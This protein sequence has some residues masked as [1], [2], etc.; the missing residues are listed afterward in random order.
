VQA[1]ARWSL[2]AQQAG[3]DADPQGY[4]FARI[5]MAEALH[6]QGDDRAALALLDAVD[7]QADKE[8]LATQG[9]KLLRA[10]I[11]AHGGQAEA[12]RAALA[13][14]RADVFGARYTAEVHYT[15]AAVERGLGNLDEAQRQAERGLACARRASSRRNGLHALA[16]VAFARGDLATTVAHLEAFARDRYHGQSGGGLLLLGQA[17]ERAGRIAEARAAYQQAVDRVGGAAWARLARGRLTHLST[18][19][20]RE[21]VKTG[22]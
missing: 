9:S 2:S 19:A 11:L 18:D 7:L 4:V 21:A 8:P 13:D 17:H 14:V 5:N 20:A 10:W 15:R 16:A 6:N 12:A 1:P 3:Q 22:S